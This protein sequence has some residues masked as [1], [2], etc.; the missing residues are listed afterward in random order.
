VPTSL[1]EVAAVLERLRIA[2]SAPIEVLDEMIAAAQGSRAASNSVPLPDGRF[3]TVKM[4]GPGV[5]HWHIDG[6]EV[7]TSAAA[8][9]VEGNR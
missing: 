9:A 1:N 4:Q 2:N 6:E 5:A 8:R 3:L 7:S